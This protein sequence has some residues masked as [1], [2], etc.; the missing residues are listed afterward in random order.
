M[1]Y[2][3]RSKVLLERLRKE[4]KM[5]EKSKQGAKEKGGSSGANQGREMAD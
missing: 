5:A 3:Y 2:L 1:N 4:G